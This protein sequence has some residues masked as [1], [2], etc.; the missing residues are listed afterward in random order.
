MI[1]TYITRHRILAHYHAAVEFALILRIATV[2][3][4]LSL[5]VWILGMDEFARV[6]TVAFPLV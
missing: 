4:Q 3:L 6:A 1:T 2:H 5:D